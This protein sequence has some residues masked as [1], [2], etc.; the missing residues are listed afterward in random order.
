MQ[1]EDV[2]PIIEILT[3]LTPGQKFLQIPVGGCQDTNVGCAWFGLADAHE[4]LFLQ[5]AQQFHL[6]FVR[7]LSHLVEKKCAA[8]C[9]LEVALA[10]L[11]SSGEGTLGMAEQLTFKQ[12]GGQGRTVD[13]DEGP[14]GTT[15][16]L[17]D[18]SGQHFLARAIFAGDE[19]RRIRY[20]D[21]PCLLQNAPHGG[22]FGLEPGGPT[23]MQNPGFEGLVSGHKGLA[24]KHPF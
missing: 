3:E 1:A 17:L 23:G 7:R 4:F 9:G 10:S 19:H 21:S 6:D 24:F 13:G 20:R 5:K 22:A 16:Q 8:I 11:V 15:A 18:M 12:V 2:E 14:I